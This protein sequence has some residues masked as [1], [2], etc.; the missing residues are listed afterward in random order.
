MVALVIVVAVVGMGIGIRIGI[1]VVIFLAQCQP[2]SKWKR[3]DSTLGS[4]APEPDSKANMLRHFFKEIITV[5]C[6]GLFAY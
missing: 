6:N 3:N 2:T 5:F 4:L 1:V